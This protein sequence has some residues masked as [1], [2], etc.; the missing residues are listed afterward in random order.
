MKQTPQ[1]K[2]NTPCPRAIWIFHL[3]VAGIS[4]KSMIALHCLK[5]ICR[6]HVQFKCRIKVIDILR[7]P[8]AAKKS[9]IVAVP[10]LIRNFPLPKIK[11]IGDLRNIEK[12][13]A[14]LHFN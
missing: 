12:T 3:Y 14:A 11:I 10:A 7:N 5:Q 1:K 8:L 6:E 4:P 9:Q 13:L 2:A